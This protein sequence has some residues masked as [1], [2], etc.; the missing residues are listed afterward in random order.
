MKKEV[1]QIRLNHETEI[2][3][4]KMNHKSVLFV[5][6]KKR[7]KS[8]NLGIHADMSCYGL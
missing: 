6:L 3:W 5:M 4:M 7:L 2:A 1:E 8:L